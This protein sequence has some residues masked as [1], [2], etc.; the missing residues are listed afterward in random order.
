MLGVGRE[1]RGREDV[2]RQNDLHALLLG[3]GEVAL[4]GVDL[5]LLEQRLAHLVALGLEEREEHASADEDAVGLGQQ[6]GDD[7]QLVGDLGAAEHDRVR[8]RGV[9]HGLAQRL[10]LLLDQQARRG[11]EHLGDVVHRGLLAVNDAEA[12]GHEHV[13]ERGELG[14]E[15]LALLVD[16]RGLA[17]IETH[18]L[19]HG[20]LAGLE[21]VDSG[22]GGR[23]DQVLCERDGLAEQFRETGGGGG[24][25]VLGLGL[26][27]RASEVSGH[28]DGGAGS[29]K[30]LD[31]GD[32]GAHAAVVGDGGAVERHVEV[33]ANQD[34]L[35]GQVAQAVNRLQ[36]VSLPS[37]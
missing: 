17:G 14:G 2:G 21:R 1:A 10:D 13:G 15:R 19:E 11:G 32:G 6:V 22:L 4:D 31:G 29:E 12:I 36:H 8:T 24:K 23:A 34:L 5:V 20:H 33:G 30:L 16:L 37:W 9:G 26:A 18:V 35:A 7:A 28:D 25:R 3:R 27:L